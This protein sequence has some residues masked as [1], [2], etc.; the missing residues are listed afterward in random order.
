MASGTT[1]VRSMGRLPRGRFRRDVDVGEEE[2]STRE[3]EE[4][5]IENE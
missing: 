1:G 3:E 2:K 5:Y 4:E